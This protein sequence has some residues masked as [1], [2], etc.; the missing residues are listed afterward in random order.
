MSAHMHKK[1]SPRGGDAHNFLR[2]PRIFPFGHL[3]CGREARKI[4]RRPRRP[5]SLFPLLRRL[6]H[7]VLHNQHRIASLQ[8]Q[9]WYRIKITFLF[10][11]LVVKK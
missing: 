1:V 4:G 11:C 8:I 3:V 6:M 2:R 9:I 10:L 7:R 5:P